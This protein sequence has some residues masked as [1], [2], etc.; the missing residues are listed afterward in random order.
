[1]FAGR[2]NLRIRTKLFITYFSVFVLMLAG[3]SALTYCLDF[4]ACIWI[5]G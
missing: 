4:H 5:I 3:S 1:M 2:G